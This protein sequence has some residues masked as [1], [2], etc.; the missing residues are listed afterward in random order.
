MVSSSIAEAT[1]RATLD[2][3]TV[4]SV[5]RFSMSKRRCNFLVLRR[6]LPNPRPLSVDLLCSCCA[7]CRSWSLP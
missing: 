7:H 2:L 6:R 3:S 4:P 5:D 1:L